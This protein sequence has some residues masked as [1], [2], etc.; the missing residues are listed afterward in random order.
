MGKRCTLAGPLPLYHHNEAIWG[1]KPFVS[2]M[3]TSYLYKYT[4]EIFQVTDLLDL[5][6]HSALFCFSFI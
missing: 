1:P 5:E 2:S 4:S 3:G 6:P